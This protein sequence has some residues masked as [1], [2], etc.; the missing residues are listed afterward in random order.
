MEEHKDRKQIRFYGKDHPLSNFYEAPF[1][2][3]S[4]IFPTNEHFYQANKSDDFYE[5]LDIIMAD[6]PKE[7]K[8]MGRDVEN[9]RNN[10][11][12][13]RLLYMWKGLKAKFQNPQLREYLLNTGDAELVENNVFDP[14]WG[15]GRNGEGRNMLGKM[16]MALREQ[17]RCGKE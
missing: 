6:T 10:W 14:Y 11:G 15:C 16:L 3:G 9:H 4:F 7:A 13:K 12:Q 1:R 17:I 8:L 2:I 5:R